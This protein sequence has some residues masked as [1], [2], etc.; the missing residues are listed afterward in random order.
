MTA[1]PTASPTAPVHRLA[2]HAIVSREGSIAAAD[3]TMPPCLVVPED[4]RRFQ[5][6]LSAAVLTILGRE[7]HERHRSE[8]TRLV[9]TSRV[10]GLERNG[11]AW[12]WNPA[13]TPLRVALRAAAPEGGSVVVAGGGRTMALMLP[14]LD[15]FDLA[16]AEQ[17]SIADG[18]PCVTGAATL[19]SLVGRVGAS[20]LRPAGREWLDRARLV[21]LWRFR[22][23]AG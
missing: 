10:G 15:A 7:G 17:C 20:G 3:G 13:E 19:D 5:A 14:H 23:A 18:R 12:L 4:Q 1:P 11:T 21:S 16:V 6:A 8:R 22:R 2:A 9:L